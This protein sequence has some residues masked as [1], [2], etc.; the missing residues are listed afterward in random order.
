MKKILSI[1]GLVGVIGLGSAFAFASDGIVEDKYNINSSNDFNYE[2]RMQDRH[3]SMMEYH[4]ED[5]DRALKDGEISQE[6]A[7]TWQDHYK[8][9]EDFHNENGFR[10]C[11]GNGRRGMRRGYRN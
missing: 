3:D 8:Y 4:R 7:Q 6:E 2:E 11:H 10:G 9:M 1:L 5:L